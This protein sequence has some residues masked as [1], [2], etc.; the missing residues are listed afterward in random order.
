MFKNYEFLENMLWFSDFQVFRA[1][2]PIIFSEFK[3]PDIKLQY[4]FVADKL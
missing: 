3:F 1:I 2:N 4:T